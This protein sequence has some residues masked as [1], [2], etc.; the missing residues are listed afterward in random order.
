VLQKL[1]FWLRSRE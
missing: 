1:L